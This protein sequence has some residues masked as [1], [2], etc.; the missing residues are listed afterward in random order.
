[1]ARACLPWCAEQTIEMRWTVLRRFAISILLV[2]VGTCAGTCAWART[3]PHYGGT[4]RVEIESDA[5]GPRSELARR[6]VFD[7]L[8][9]M[10]ADGVASPSL[11]I[12]WASENN[13]HRWQFWLRPGVRFQDGAALTSAAVEAALA[14][15]CGT[16]C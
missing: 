15:S 14:G 2:L 10:N 6:L 12:R 3:R 16:S 7:G 8:T 5:W 11:A 1:M 4:L 9:R 13:D